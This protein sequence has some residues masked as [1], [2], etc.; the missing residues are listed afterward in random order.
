ML[1][2]HNSELYKVVNDMFIDPEDKE[3]MKAFL[4]GGYIG[5]GTITDNTYRLLANYNRNFNTIYIDNIGSDFSSGHLV[6]Y[7]L[8]DGNM[9]RNNMNGTMFHERLFNNINNFINYEGIGQEFFNRLL[10]TLEQYMIE[11]ECLIL[12]GHNNRML[13]HRTEMCIFNM[14]NEALVIK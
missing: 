6:V 11:V 8:Q 5:N 9:K 3:V 13:N 4:T 2:I 1:I 14:M 12:N 10:V 7:S